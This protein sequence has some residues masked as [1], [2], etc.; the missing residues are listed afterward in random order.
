MEVKAEPMFEHASLVRPCHGESVSGDTVYVAPFAQG[1][2]GERR[3]EGLLVAIVDV[4]GH[5]PEAHALACT[6]DEFLIEHASS[7]V[8]ALMSHL[9]RRLRG[10]RGAAVG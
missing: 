2:E 3:E 10:T 4:L 9:H 5:G 1:E 8:S 6:I 7:D